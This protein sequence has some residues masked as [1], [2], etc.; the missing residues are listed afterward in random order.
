M[1]VAHDTSGQLHQLF[2]I[3]G[4]PAVVLIEGGVIRIKANALSIDRRLPE[5]KERFD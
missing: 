4:L 5:L 1:A 2:Q 3:D